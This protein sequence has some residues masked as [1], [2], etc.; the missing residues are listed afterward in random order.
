VQ[1]SFSHAVP[2]NRLG[3]VLQ[4]ILMLW[5]RL[6][7]PF[8]IFRNFMG[9]SR[10]VHFTKGKIRRFMLVHFHK[11]Y[12]EEQLN[13]RQGECNQCGSCC[14]MLMTCPMLTK[15]GGC[16]AYGVCRPQSCKTFPID[17]RDIDEVN[18][19]GHICSYRFPP[20]TSNVTRK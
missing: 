11:E 7:A 13:S 3:K 9:T 1:E 12:V 19:T 8:G 17:Q 15:E 10:A 20:S 16:M 14:N 6:T 5:A 18:L 4:Q 2:Q